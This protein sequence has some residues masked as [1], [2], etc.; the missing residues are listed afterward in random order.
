MTNYDDTLVRLGV[1]G[2]FR[3]GPLGTTAPI[4]MA[5]Y[6]A[7]VVDLGW[8]SDEGITENRE[9]DTTP[10]TPWQSNSPIR[11][12]TTSEII[13]FETILWSTSFDTISLYFKTKAED[14]TE[15]AGVV[16]F[17]DGNIK[18]PDRRFFA[19]DVID[20]IYARRALIPNGEVT[21]RAGLTYKKDELVG[22][23]VTVT[24]YPGAEGWSVKRLFKEGWS[25]PTTP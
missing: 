20:G 24:A 22:M 2:A 16:E 5:P 13:T 6:V 23:G 11:V 10:F 7:P 18:D 3:T 4:G 17:V 15:T 12:A 25:I 1:T 21:E 19:V 9:T 14:M 8:I